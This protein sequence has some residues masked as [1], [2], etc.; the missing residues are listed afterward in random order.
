MAAAS[1]TKL[2]IET[3]DWN[4]EHQQELANKGTTTLT[5]QSTGGKR[6]TF[7]ISGNVSNG[8][9]IQVVEKVGSWHAS[10][11][12]ENENC[13][14]VLRHVLTNI[15]DRNDKKLFILKHQT[16][17]SKTE[18]FYTIVTELN[19]FRAARLSKEFFTF[20]EQPN[21]E[22]SSVELHVLNDLSSY[23]EFLKS[24]QAVSIALDDPQKMV[25]IVEQFPK[26]LREM[27]YS[28]ICAHITSDKFI[29]AFNK[30]NSEPQLSSLIKL[31]GKKAVKYLLFNK[32]SLNP[33]LEA[34][35]PAHQAVLWRFLEHIP[36][37]A[38][39]RL[40]Q[41]LFYTA[42]S[43]MANTDSLQYSHDE[44]SPVVWAAI[45]NDPALN[46][47]IETLLKTDLRKGCVLIR[48]LAEHRMGVVDCSTLVKVL[49]QVG[50]I[51]TEPELTKSQQDDRQSAWYK[52]SSA[53]KMVIDRQDKAKKELK[54]C[55][56]ALDDAESKA[57]PRTT[58][59]FIPSFESSPVQIQDVIKGIRRPPPLETIAEVL[60]L[61]TQKQLGTLS[62]LTLFLIPYLDNLKT[63]N[64]AILVLS[65]LV[66]SSSGQI[67]QQ[68]IT[69]LFMHTLA[70]PTMA[71]HV[72]VLV[73]NFIASH[74]S[75]TITTDELKDVLQNTQ[76]VEH[77]LI[78]AAYQC[79]PKEHKALA[80]MFI[81][82][83]MVNSQQKILDILLP[84]KEPRVII[85]FS[86]KKNFA[87][88]LAEMEGFLAGMLTAKQD[89]QQGLDV[90]MKRVYS[91][92]R[93][94]TSEQV[95]KGL[96]Q[97]LRNTEESQRKQ[98]LTNTVKLILYIES[99]NVKAGATFIECCAM[100]PIQAKQ[101]ILALEEESTGLTSK[102]KLPLL[103]T[104][105][106]E[107]VLSLFARSG[108]YQP[109]QSL[110][111]QY[112]PKLKQAFQRVS[113]AEAATKIQATDANEEAEIQA[114]DSEEKAKILASHAEEKAKI[115]ASHAEE[116][117][118]ILAS[119][120]EEKAKILASHAEEKAKIQVHVSALIQTAPKQMTG[121]A[122]NEFSQILSDEDF[123]QAC[124]KLPAELLRELFVYQ[125]DK[126]KVFYK[127]VGIAHMR[128]E[129]VREYM[130]NELIY[131]YVS[132]TKSTYRAEVA[133]ALTLEQKQTYLTYLQQ[134]YG[135]SYLIHVVRLLMPIAP[136]DRSQFLLESFP[137]Q[138][139]K[140]QQEII[141]AGIK[142]VDN[143]TAT[144]GRI[145]LL[146]S[147]LDD[148][149][150]PQ[151]LDKLSPELRQE[152]EESL[153]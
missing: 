1:N 117:A 127:F 52:S 75:P 28:R 93:C 32:G 9:G 7:Q 143:D 135:D 109:L 58:G 90:M 108:R 138:G 49:N 132:T 38:D 27:A 13:S 70:H 94:L 126:A 95:Y 66:N 79:L 29:P 144:V 12:S 42:V 112:A 59:M 35:T 25:L 96:E 120:A 64:M 113:E 55:M 152:V 69:S 41:S 116:K 110:L 83:K 33:L 134:E 76:E 128:S 50:A 142:A 5:C 139:E 81:A 150:R 131:D 51:I 111:E 148:T 68:I 11:Q 140:L 101:A 34:T 106:D 115:L 16:L 74:G 53:Q 125:S 137:D 123:A 105:P 8:E 26:P 145:T 87:V 89:Q 17:K 97:A 22:H 37:G 62:E 77:T 21:A 4:T 104:L 136:E 45:K 133:Q 91:I 61:L 60:P 84:S 78:S 88:Q 130:S 122:L 67:Q 149:H 119:H 15:D 6:H 18:V 92:K 47:Y 54:Q 19:P 48:V 72:K 153:S 36:A 39:E 57:R 151:L 107:E 86:R 23:K 46:S 129:I 146:A 43:G 103:E 31:M 14:V 65:T 56:Q 85:G 63:R 118:K 114:S 82:Q 80:G 40:V 124:S 2:N 10:K 20:S 100:L 71:P 102:Q 3:L 141:I 99:L 73:L 121:W 24:E 147:M 98:V 44:F 30:L